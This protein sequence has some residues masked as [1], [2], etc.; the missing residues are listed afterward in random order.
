MFQ[1]I[2]VALWKALPQF[3]GDSSARPFVYRVA[4]NTAIRFVTS[5]NR[6]TAQEGAVLE[7][8]AEPASLDNPERNAIRNQQWQT[9]WRG[10]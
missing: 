9:L 10:A 1:E 5:H 2:A 7:L 3:R 6:R 4:H 8:G